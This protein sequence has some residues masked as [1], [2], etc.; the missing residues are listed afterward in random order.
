V[1]LARAEKW[2]WQ[3]EKVDTVGGT[4]EKIKP[5]GRGERMK[6]GTGPPFEFKRREKGNRGGEWKGEGG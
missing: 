6:L 3:W 4:D 5:R 1:A 2:R